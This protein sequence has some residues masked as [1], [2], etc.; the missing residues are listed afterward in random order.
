MF[1]TTSLSARDVDA[2]SVSVKLTRKLEE[3]AEKLDV[4]VDQLEVV[5]HI[6]MYYYNKREYARDRCIVVM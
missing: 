1:D 2:P 3:L 5:F 6:C 4:S